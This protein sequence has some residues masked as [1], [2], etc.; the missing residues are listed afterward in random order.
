MSEYTKGLYNSSG[1]GIEYS[2]EIEYDT[3]I[4]TVDDIE[5]RIA[6]DNKYPIIRDNKIKRCC[7]IS[8]EFLKVIFYYLKYNINATKESKTKDE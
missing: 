2:A 3:Y 7:V 4:E 5:D 1:A 8:L 6:D